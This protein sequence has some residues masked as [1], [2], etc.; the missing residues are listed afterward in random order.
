MKTRA[1]TALLGAALLAGCSGA[2]P[3]PILTSPLSGDA[4]PPAEAGSGG[5][6]GAPTDVAATD[7]AAAVDATLGESEASSGPAAHDA[8]AEDFGQASAD[9]AKTDATHVAPLPSLHVVG[10]RIYD[11]ATPIVLI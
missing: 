6:N 5:G 8:A 2:N 10:N 4:D 1:T 3:G 7:V 11:N 9:G